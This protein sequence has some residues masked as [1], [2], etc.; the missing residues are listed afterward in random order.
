MRERS[1]VRLSVTPST[2][3]S[4]LRV[5][6]DIGERQDDHREAR[7]SGFFG[8]WVRRKLRVSGRTDF[9]RIDPDRHGDVLELGQ[10]E[11]AD[12]KIE[13][14]PHLTIGVLGKADRSRVANAL[15]PRGDVD[16][17]AH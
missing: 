3:C 11:I 9:E 2:K 15:Q 16:A 8:R 17:V 10:A 7:R 12:L 5:A 1:V 13:P 14:T 4:W 6:A